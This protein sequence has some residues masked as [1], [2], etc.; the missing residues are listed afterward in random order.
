MSFKER[1]ELHYRKEESNKIMN[2]YPSRIPIIVEKAKGCM[3]DDIDKKK[4]LAP[5]DLKVNQ[6]LYVIRR[7]IKLGPEQSIFLLI[8][9][10]LCSSNTS[11]VEVYEKHADKD[12]FLY[13]KYA[14]ENTFG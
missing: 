12:G 13:I 9:G 6:L 5:K 4:Y 11:L 10:E 1:Y 8:G 14:S 7:R 2:K 3:L